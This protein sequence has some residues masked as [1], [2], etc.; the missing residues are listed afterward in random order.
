MGKTKIA[1]GWLFAIAFIVILIL[2]ITS[3][4][5][6]DRTYRS[7]Y[8]SYW[9]LADRSSTL[10][11]KEQYVTQF[12]NNIQ[13]HRS[14]FVDYNAVIVQT[15]DNNFDNN[16]N[17]VITLRDRLHTIQ[18][19]NESSFEYQTAIQQITGQ[20]MGQADAMMSDIEGSWY[21][22]NYPCLWSWYF[23]LMIVLEFFLITVGIALLT[24]GYSEY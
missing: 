22:K 7:K 19:M 9:Q 18:Q 6:A 3:G 17:A 4:I 8:G 14:E 24:S 12:V 16:L 5:N 15:P 1:F 2:L 13:A 23:G 20:E 11:A 10:Q 21:L